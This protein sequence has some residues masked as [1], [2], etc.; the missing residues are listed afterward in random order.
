M[1]APW[2]WLCLGTLLQAPPSSQFLQG[3]PGPRLCSYVTRVRAHHVARSG[4]SH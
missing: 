2:G 1:A 3:P 4:L